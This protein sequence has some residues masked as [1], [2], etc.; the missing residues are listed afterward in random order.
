[1]FHSAST[2]ERL[3]PNQTFIQPTESEFDEIER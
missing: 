1:V 2:I 3:K